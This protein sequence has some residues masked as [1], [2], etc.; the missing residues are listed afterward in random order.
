MPRARAAAITG[1]RLTVMLPLVNTW[2]V[3]HFKQFLIII[4]CINI[5][6]KIDDLY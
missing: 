1:R 4:V 6:V 2:A 5:D 3:T